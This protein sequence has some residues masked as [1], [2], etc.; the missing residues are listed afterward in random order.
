MYFS[1]VLGS[2]E[3]EPSDAQPIAKT[4]MF[5]LFHAQY[6]N[7]ENQRIITELASGTSKLRILSVTVAFGICIDIQNIRQVIH[8]GIPY[9]IEEYFQEAGRCG[10]DGLPSKALVYFKA[11][12]IYP[13]QKSKWLMSCENM[14]QQTNARE[15]LFYNILDM[16][17]PDE[18]VHSMHVVITTKRPVCMLSNVS[19][20]SWP[21][22]W[23]TPVKQNH[24]LW[25][26]K[27]LSKSKAEKLRQDFTDYRLSLDG[28][29]RSSVGGITLDTGF[30]IQLID[31]IVDNALCLPSV[32]RVMMDFAVFSIAHAQ[33]VYNRVQKYHWCLLS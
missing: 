15:K 9:T 6:P 31:K 1:E 27:V 24:L 7:H 5:T 28:S 23:K 29:G 17:L 2:E 25:I 4:R 14:L 18:V 10:R 30:S 3:Y 21:I 13:S 33:A 20:S 32:E 26:I 16:K 8:I 12:M 19:T 11:Y 22:P